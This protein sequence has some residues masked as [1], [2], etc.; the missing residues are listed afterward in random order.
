MGFIRDQLQS[1]FPSASTSTIAQAISN[2]Q[3]LPEAIDHLFSTNR[4]NTK[5]IY[6]ELNLGHAKKEETFWQKP[7]FNLTTNSYQICVK[8]IA[9]SDCTG[10]GSS[11]MFFFVFNIVF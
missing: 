3:N 1:M 10:F 8:G 2:S 6:N 4:S 5:G 11:V 7:A 9:N